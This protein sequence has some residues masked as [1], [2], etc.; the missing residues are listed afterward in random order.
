MGSLDC[1]TRKSDQTME[2]EVKISQQVA[3]NIRPAKWQDF[4]NALNPNGVNVGMTLLVGTPTDGLKAYRLS[5]V[6]NVNELKKQIDRRQVWVVV[7]GFDSEVKII[8]SK[9][10]N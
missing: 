6:R 7:T 3:L 8:E 2:K 1:W 4:K 10:T 9:S 5:E